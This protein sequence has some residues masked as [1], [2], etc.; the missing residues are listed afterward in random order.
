MNTQ[1]PIKFVRQLNKAMNIKCI[2]VRLSALY[3]ISDKAYK[4]QCFDGSSA[5]VPASQIFGQDNDVIKSKA[6]WISEWI[7]KQTKLQYSDKKIG[8]FN[9][10]TREKIPSHRLIN[11]YS[12]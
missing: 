11:E 5:I 8:W 9:S 2:S 1:L 6:Y 10:V 3:P 7:V 12:K 4:A